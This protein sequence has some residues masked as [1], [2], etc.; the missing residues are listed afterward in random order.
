MKRKHSRQKALVLSIRNTLS[1]IAFWQAAG[2]LLLLL[3]VWVNET[4]DLA[5]LIYGM[6][7]T[8]PN[9]TRGCLATAGVLLAAIIV[10][11]HTYVQ[12]RSIISGMLTICSYCHKITLDKEVWQRIEDHLARNPLLRLSHGI[13]PDCFVKVQESLDKE[14]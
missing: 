6:P 1:Y 12:Q 11:G 10:V 8:P 13:C 9:V 4:L 7:P 2:F 3:L 5:A 14:T